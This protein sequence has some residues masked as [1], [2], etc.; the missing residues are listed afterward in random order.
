MFPAP[1]PGSSTAGESCWLP[2]P[3]RKPWPPITPRISLVASG[4]GVKQPVELLFSLAV[5]RQPAFPSRTASTPSRVAAAGRGL[6]HRRGRRARPEQVERTGTSSAATAAHRA[7]LGRGTGQPGALGPG[8]PP[9]AVGRNHGDTM[10]L[11]AQPVSG[12]VQDLRCGRGGPA[13]EVGRQLRRGFRAGCEHPRPHLDPARDADQRHV[14]ADGRR[15]V[16]R[17]PVTAGEQQ[18][19]RLGREER[20]GRLGIRRRSSAARGRPRPATTAGIPQASATSAPMGPGA[21]R[22]CASASSR[23]RRRARAARSGLTGV[24]PRSAAAARRAGP[25]LPCSPTRPPIPATGLTSSPTRPDATLLPIVSYSR[26]SSA[27]TWSSAR[28]VTRD[29]LVDLLLGH[30]E[31]RRERDGVGGRERAR[32]YHARLAVGDPRR[33]ALRRIEGAQR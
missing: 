29:H 30:D 9:A 23:R 5:P 2:R 15:D 20:G 24:P 8:Q 14:Q 25:S 18:H 28:R 31:R 3:S 17:C 16:T 12:R 19:V 33:D 32:Q 21:V 27:D 4:L 6:A 11:R 22:I 13:Q 7:R 1:H 26:S 10:E